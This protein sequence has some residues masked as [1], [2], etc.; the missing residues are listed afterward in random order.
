MTGPH[1]LAHPG[2][3]LLHL[4]WG[5]QPRGGHGLPARRHLVDDRHV[6]VA[7]DHHGRGAG[8]RGGRHD[9]Q[10]G[11]P[12]LPVI[13]AALVAQGGPLLD[14]EAMLLVDDHHPEG[15]EDHLIG[16]QGVGAHHQI[17]GPGGQS[18]PDVGPFARSGA[19]GEQSHPQRPLTGQGR[20]VGHGQAVDQTPDLDGV[21][22]GQDL[23]G[24]HQCALIAA[25]HPHEQRGHGH[26]RLARADVALEQ[27]VHGQR[28]AQVAGQVG[29]RP[30]LG[31]GQ[32]EVQPGDELLHQGGAV[33]PGGDVD[34]TPGVLVEPLA[35]QH[36]G[37][38][39]PE[40]L[41]EG[42][43]FP[44]R[45]HLVHGHRPVDALEGRGAVDQ[46]VVGPD[47]VVQRVG[48]RSGPVQ[49]LVDQPADAGRRE[50]GLLGE[51]VD[52]V[53]PTRRRAVVIGGRL[54]GAPQDLGGGVDH[55][56][57]VAE[58]G[59]R[60]EEQG[61]GPD[62]Q[63]SGPP[64]LVEERHLDPPARVDDLQLHPCRWPSPPSP[65]HRWGADPTHGGQH[66]GLLPLGQPV[67]GEQAGAVDVATRIVGDQVEDG[68]DAELGQVAG[69]RLPHTP[70]HRH[71]QVG[72]LLQP[73]TRNLGPGT[74]WR[75]RL[76]HSMEN[77]Y[78]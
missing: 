26:H 66:G 4:Q 2:P 7:E 42:Q 67:D 34:D 75:R 33:G 24:G 17:D 28:I 39:E 70:Q 61:Q 69:R 68:D 16:Q 51:W 15:V 41:V 38:L 43:P 8:D 60:T 23:G 59:D 29:H 56:Q 45:L 32:G 50:A 64:R 49:G 22:F 46:A 76:R 57:G 36:Q 31:R 1:L 74:G 27:T 19:T 58:R 18:L 21:L 65:T 9:Q 72:Q 48:E 35:P 52:R 3:G 55:L 53:D 71:G 25:L 14:T 47:G 37:Q 62:R 30:G 12:P 63:L 13:A 20:R 73:S 78:G 40:Q 11:V 10:V 54:V 77:R 44:G 5:T 6:Q